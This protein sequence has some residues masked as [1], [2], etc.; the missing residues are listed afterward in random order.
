MEFETS[1]VLDDTDREILALLEEDARLGYAEIGKKLGLT[2]QTVKNRVN[3]LEEMGV[4]RGYRT[5]VDTAADR[6]VILF[7][8]DMEFTPEAFVEGVEYLKK[9]P[10]VRKLYQVTGSF[11]LHMVSFADSAMQLQEYTDRLGMELKGITSMKISVVMSVLK[12]NGGV[13]HE[14]RCEK[15]EHMEEQ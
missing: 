14:I 15:S 1:R 6:R 13:G 7:F 4:I 10:M 11:R 9:E 2:R 3:I 5:I 12:Q 8:I